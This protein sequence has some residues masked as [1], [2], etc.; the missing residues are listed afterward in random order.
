M[1]KIDML[2]AGRGD[3]LWIEYGDPENPH[4]VL[5]DGGV[6]STHRT[7]RDR[8]EKLSEDR[9]RLDLL[10]VTHIDL[11]HIA[12]VL[13][14]FRNPVPGL[15]IGDVWFNAWDHLGQDQP[16]PVLPPAEDKDDGLLGPKQAERLDFY[17]KR[18]GQPWNVAFGGGAVEVGSERAPLPTRELAGGMKLTLLSPTRER[19]RALAKDWSRVIKGVDLVPGAAGAAL[20]GFDEA[21]E[22]DVLL[23]PAPVPPPPDVATLAAGPFAADTSRANG[24]SIAFLAEYGGKRCLFT[25]DAWAG[26][27]TAAVRRL[28]AAE[29]DRVLAVDALKL[30]HHGGRKN[31]DA[32]LLSALACNRYLVS[33]DG[34]YYDHPQP[35][36]MARAIVHG[37]QRGEPRLFFNYRSPETGVWDDRR[38]FRATGRTYEPV[39]P[40]SSG[41]L[42]VDL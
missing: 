17:L 31:T 16:E 29:G 15:A 8:L 19:L 30:S 25:G 23:G 27:V 34:S 36:S 14:L 24:S 22:D 13:E 18:A 12:G 3:C 20:E 32:E 9:R 42:A 5:I 39:Y 40:V 1:F 41:G 7:I 35:E 2:P 38:L 21:D 26:D 33:T 4:R 11:D 28:A 10:A 37:R 6:Q